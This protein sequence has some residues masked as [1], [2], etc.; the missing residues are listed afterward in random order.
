MDHSLSTTWYRYT[1]RGDPETPI[2]RTQVPAHVFPRMRGPSEAGSG[3]QADTK[4]RGETETSPTRTGEV[5]DN[6]NLCNVCNTEMNS[7]PSPYLN[8]TRPAETHRGINNTS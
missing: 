5:D 1:E 7:A 2:P 3:K 4:S 6:P 8:V